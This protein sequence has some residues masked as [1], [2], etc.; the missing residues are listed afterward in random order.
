LAV[1]FARWLDVRFA[2]WCDM[3]IDKLL[4][5]VPNA[6]RD[7]PPQTLTP[8]MKK[9]I[10]QRVN[11][12]VKHQVGASYASLGK[13]IQ[14]TFNV[15]KRELILA[16]KYPELCALLDC[17]PNPKALQG[18]LVEPVATFKLPMGKVLIDESELAELNQRRKTEFS[19]NGY[20]SLILGINDDSRFLIQPHG[21]VT[22]ISRLRDDDFVGTFETI[23]RELKFRGYHVVKDTPENKLETIEKIVTAKFIA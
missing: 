4:K 9:H 7:L 14:D 2:V 15:N 1:N 20:A 8:A 23:V 6:L 13:L 10:N 19:S 17:E 12:L 3:Q 18:E 22:A 16:S 11:Y 21:D 5:T